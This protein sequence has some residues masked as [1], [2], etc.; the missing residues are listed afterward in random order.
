[1][2][3]TH[4]TPLVSII[5]PT[6]NR[7]W[8]IQRAI[9]SVL[10]Q[11]YTHFELIVVDDGSTD[12]TPGILSSYGDALKIFAQKNSG[13]SA[14]RNRGILN[15]TGSLIAFLDSDDYWLPKKLS[16]Q[17]DFFV[18][19]PDALICQTEE[20]WIKNGR[21]VNPGKRHK[22]PSGKMFSE[23]LHL[24]LISPSAVMVRR[25]LLDDVGVFDETLPAC[26]DYDLWLRVTCRYA[27]P[28][29]DSPLIIKT[30]GHP[31]Q[32]SASPSLDKYRIA[33]ILK[34][35]NSNLLT[36]D[37]LKDA[38]AVLKEKCRIYADGCAKRGRTDEAAYYHRVAMNPFML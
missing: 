30:G 28:L 27:V 34:I 22:K 23:S 31:D 16:A 20:T 29:I 8:S 3:S 1:M 6:Y 13:V 32:L 14:A 11:D 35:L 19:H 36:D 15:A 18:S 38:L 26:E 5:I 21:Q 37:Q 4:S 17:V 2:K 12:D 9:D 10:R 24:C 7:A 33:A 25:E